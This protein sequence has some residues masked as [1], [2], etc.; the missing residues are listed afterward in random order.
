MHA[1][2]LWHSDRTG[3]RLARSALVPFSWAYAA[4][5]E[6]YL[7]LYKSGLKRAREPHQP[8]V[9]VGNLQ[10]GGSGKTPV[11]L[12]LAKLLRELGHEVTVSSS[13]YGAPRAERASLAP[14]GQL[15]ASE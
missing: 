2:E 3:A 9:C 13:G 6:M 15:S 4:G 5:W 11:T 8:V 7:A 10:V 1:S 12:K 14:D